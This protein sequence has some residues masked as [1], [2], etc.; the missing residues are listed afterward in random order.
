MMGESHAMLQSTTSSLQSN[1]LKDD[2]C[3]T[4]EL[5][6]TQVAAMLRNPVRHCA[7]DVAYCKPAV[8]CIT[9]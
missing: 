9:F 1:G 6:V 5:V 2:E 3:D 8:H 7:T 4:C